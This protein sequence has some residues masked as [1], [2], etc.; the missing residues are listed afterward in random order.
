MN[1]VQLRKL[2]REAVKAELKNY[3]SNML[4]ESALAL[5]SILATTLATLVATGKGKDLLLTPYEIYEKF[6]GNRKLKSILKR[7]ASDPE[8]MAAAK[9]PNKSGWKELIASKLTDDEKGY[10]DG[11]VWTGNDF[12]TISRKDFR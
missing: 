7:L 9:N 5:F 6:R 11:E 3:K 8:V 12:R 1:E 2:I 4:N 10:I